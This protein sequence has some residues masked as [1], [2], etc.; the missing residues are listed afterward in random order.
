MKDAKEMS[1]ACH[2]VLSGIFLREDARQAGRQE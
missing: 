2:Y 1:Y